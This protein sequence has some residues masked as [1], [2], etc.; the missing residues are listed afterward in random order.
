MEPVYYDEWSS[1]DDVKTAYPELPPEDQIVF[2]GYTYEDYSGNALVVWVDEDGQWWENDD[3]HCSCNVLEH[4]EPEKTLLEAVT[5][6]KHWPGLLEAIQ[7]HQCRTEGCQN[8]RL[9]GS[10]ECEDHVAGSYYN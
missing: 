8:E 4:W 6:Y 10:S 5:K 1:Y 7:S 9:F 2:A 3:G